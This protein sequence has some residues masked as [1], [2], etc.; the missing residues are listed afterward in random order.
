MAQLLA[1]RSKYKVRGVWRELP[2][3][4]GDIIAKATGTR[5]FLIESISGNWIKL[6][7]VAT[8]RAD[9]WDM[10][11]E[12]KVLSWNDEEMCVEHRLDE[13][14]SWCD[15]CIDSKRNCKIK[16]CHHHDLP[17][18]TICPRA[19]TPCLSHS[20]FEDHCAECQSVN[21]T[22]P[23]S[24]PTTS[25][26]DNM[27]STQTVK[28]LGGD[29]GQVVTNLNGEI[30]VLW[31]GEPQVGKKKDADD[32]VTDARTR[33]KDEADTKLQQVLANLFA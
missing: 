4:A 29:A 2:L 15:N 28:V 13:W 27:F 24:P 26:K 5:G 14:K 1:N 22:A 16:R 30:V 17:S 31:Q 3:Q 8:G 25:S 21:K 10:W 20:R 7:N 11:Q 32:V 9:E 18:C 33:A 6:R 23:P 12:V 19:P